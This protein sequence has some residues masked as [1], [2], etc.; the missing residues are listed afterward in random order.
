MPVADLQT[1]TDRVARALPNLPTVNVLQST[2]DTRGELRAYLERQGAMGDA[3]GAFHKGELYLFADNLASMERAEH[4]L[5][6]HE[7]GHAGLAGMLGADKARVLQSLLNL[8]DGLNRRARA[9]AK[10]LNVPL[11]T[12]V[13]EVL[14]DMKP[15]D[16]V[17][18][19]GWRK[20]VHR[21]QRWLDRSGF[22]A[23]AKQMR[24]W[25]EG[26]LTDQQQADMLAADLMFAA[27]DYLAGR[28][29][30]LF[31]LD[32]RQE[33]AAAA[34]ADAAWS[35][36]ASEGFPSVELRGGVLP[37]AGCHRVEGKHAGFVRPIAQDDEAE[38]LAIP[39]KQRAEVR[40]RWA[41]GSR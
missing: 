10:R 29:Q 41:T 5:A 25:M 31:T 37:D 40:R 13:E 26:R 11:L 17:R 12:A 1:M 32:G 6:T 30:R 9:E 27:H 38:L 33:A 23:L 39:R 22:K 35:F 3:E 7:A 18:L 24:Q 28:D 36:A 19:E 21:V 16:L 8:N 15:A 34:L 2:Q 14:V 20:V 4:V